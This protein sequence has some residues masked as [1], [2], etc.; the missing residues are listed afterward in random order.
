M[1]LPSLPLQHL[2]LAASMPLRCSRR[3]IVSMC[4]EEFPLITSSTNPRLKLIKRLHAK[5]HREREGLVL[6]VRALSPRQ[7]AQ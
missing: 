6:L 2:L 1:R 7:F 5:K 4:A 3:S